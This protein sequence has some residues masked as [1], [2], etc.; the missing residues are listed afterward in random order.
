MD[1]LYL[2]T[3]AEFPV[4]APNYASDSLVS[5]LHIFSLLELHF[6][7]TAQSSEFSVQKQ[8][9]LTSSMLIVLFYSYIIDTLLISYKV[10]RKAGVGK[11]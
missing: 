5:A 6:L 7:T 10:F 9:E 4:S 1:L 3:A 11:I 8:F 2:P